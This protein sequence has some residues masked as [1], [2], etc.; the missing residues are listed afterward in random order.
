ADKFLFTFNARKFYD[1]TSSNNKQTLQRLPEIGIYY[2]DTPVFKDLY[3]NATLAYTNFYREEGP[4]ASR[5]IFFPELSLPV[6]FLGR[7]FYSS[8]TFENGIYLPSN[9][10]GTDKSFSTVHFVERLPLFFDR[11]WGKTD[12]KNV[13]EVVYSY[14]PK[15]YNNPRFDTL[16][17]IDKENQIKFVLRNYT[18]Y[19][20]RL[21]L[22]WYLEGGYSFLGSFSYAPF[23]YLLSLPFAGQQLST[24]FN[25]TV[26]NKNLMPIRS[27]VSLSP[28]P[29]LSLSSD[30]LY[31][32]NSSRF[33]N[34]TSYL[35]LNLK[36]SNI[37]LGYVAS[38]DFFGNRLTDQTLLSA[39]TLYKNVNIN[40]G[41]VHDNRINKDL[42]RQMRLDYTGAC[43]S[44]GV[45]LRDT[46][47]GNRKKYIKEVFL[48]FNVF[49]LQ[50]FTLPLKR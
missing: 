31:D 11:R 16:D 4:R 17:N 3:F 15:G 40:L 37:T 18:A 43:W 24:T 10:S 9:L 33:L 29:F 30:T 49:D 26:V 45:L 1:T 5:I 42:L 25:K 47:D 13:F 23:Q 32:P 39:N 28:L 7:T 48:A 19:D 22:S 2:K 27:I 21:L 46:Y 12:F 36:N 38:K 8:F 50:R 44:L 6:N 41:V 20:G 14:R 35:S 34:N